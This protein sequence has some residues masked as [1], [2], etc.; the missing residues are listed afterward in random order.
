MADDT[1]REQPKECA[2]IYDVLYT[3][4]VLRKTKTWRDGRLYKFKV[5]VVACLPLVTTV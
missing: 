1:G 3:G 4:H 2:Q 5:Y